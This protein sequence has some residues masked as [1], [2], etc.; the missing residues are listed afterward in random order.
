MLNLVALSHMVKPPCV[1]AMDF[2][3]R[4][5]LTAARGIADAGVY[6]RTA[7]LSFIAGQA[8]RIR[9]S[10]SAVRVNDELRKLSYVAD[11]QPSNKWS[12][13]NLVS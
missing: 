9:G 10:T 3:C 4:K 7:T 11:V 1:V 13:V 12:E 2:S 6:L 8:K 5:S